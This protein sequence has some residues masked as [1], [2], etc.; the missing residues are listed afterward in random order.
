M[1]T[2]IIG[3][4]IVGLSIARELVLRGHKDVTV[5]E[6]EP[7]LGAHSSGRNSGVVHA[8]IYY[9]PG[10][11]KALFSVDGHRRLLEF[12]REKNL[13]HEICG[14]V[15]VAMREE[16]VPQLDVLEKRATDNGVRIERITLSR[17]KELEPEAHSFDSALWS[18][19][20]AII[21]SK[22]VLAAL[23]TEIE[24]HGGSIVFG[25]Q[26]TRIDTDHNSIHTPKRELKYEFLINAAGL[27][28]DKIAH[29]MGIGL[30]YRILPFKGIYYG[31]DEAY[32]KRIRG[33]IYP[34][35]D[36]NMP[37]LGVH[38]TKTLA[39]KVL[40]GPTAIPAFGRENY[41]FFS[42]LDIRESPKI[43]ANLMGLMWRNPDNF[44]NYV[45]EEFSRY[46]PKNFYLEAKRL[47]PSLM[48]ADVKTVAKVGIRAQLYHRTKGRLEMDFNI[49]KGQNSIHVLNAVSPAFTCGLSFATYVV[50]QMG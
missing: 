26:V 21:D 48:P 43:T 5:L 37:F 14:K 31:T 41:G 27:H 8:G 49:E 17:L 7:A 18:P 38:V 35:P 6:K 46:F 44:R 12:C 11:R 22:A 23:Q 30:D 33:L 24:S 47:T 32:S 25:E 13:P 34:T 10:S 9:P 50:D 2:V 19:N 45:T 28:A 29:Q 3:A 15:I 39:G 36:L 1:K 4:G 20:T 42:G 40:L 16:L